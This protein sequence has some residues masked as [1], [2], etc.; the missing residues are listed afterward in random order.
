MKLTRFETCIS[1]ISRK[2][3]QEFVKLSWLRAVPQR[4]LYPIPVNIKGHF[5][6][7]VR[8]SPEVRPL[9]TGDP[10]PTAKEVAA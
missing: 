9:G 5:L 1:L 3:K 4:N 8:I 10:F 6:Q 7:S 2:L